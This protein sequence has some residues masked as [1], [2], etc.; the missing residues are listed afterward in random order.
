M[1]T[2]PGL[3]MKIT[4]DTAGLSRGMNRTEKALAGLKS[5]TDRA[6]ASLRTLVS[7]EVG[8]ILAN[9]FNSAANSALN[10]ANSLRGSI[11]ETA[12]LA[13]R[14][15]IAVEALQGLQVAAALSGVNNFS[16]A[17]SKLNVRLGQAAQGN[18][19][20]LD[21][22]NMLGLSFA[23]LEK[24]SPEDRF[25]AV[26]EAIRLLPTELER[27]AAAVKLFEEGGI[28]LLP[29]FAQNLDEITARAERLGIIL[30]SDQTKSIEE[31]NDALY[32]VR[33][34][35]D[36]I[37]GQVTANLAPIITELA[38]Q[39][40]AFV[41][42]YK[43]L[44]EGTG[45]TAL[46][47]SITDAILVGVEF[48]AGVFDAIIS[49][50]DAWGVSFSSAAEFF[51]GAVDIFSRVV[52]FLETVF[53]TAQ[54]FFMFYWSGV[55]K[56]LSELVGLFDQDSKQ[57]LQI[58]SEELFNGSLAAIDR[59]A[60]AAGRIIGAA[61]DATDPGKPGPAQQFVKELQA[62]LEKMRADRGKPKPGEEPPTQPQMGGAAAAAQQA[63][64]AI[65][66]GGQLVDEQAF[67][68][69]DNFRLLGEERQRLLTEQV[70]ASGDLDS[71]NNQALQASDLRSG[72][73]STFLDLA[74][75]RDPALETAK[76]QFE[77]LK[78]IREALENNRVAFEIAGALA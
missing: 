75:G 4:A 34:T 19:D 72:G 6:A 49:G 28:Q 11:D 31:M 26:A 55:T 60:E 54:Y 73:L 57:Y 74:L 62:M 77:E 69:M 58:L 53:A 8:K 32:L 16:E 44:G 59:A 38:N 12:K 27:S 45:G 7:I 64:I 70:K 14:T 76:Q 40:L 24:M 61:A 10:L 51:S 46:A 30:S 39:F 21:T 17:I 35:F 13:Q 29:L 18:K 56:V 15:G 23:D 22:L 1:A 3:A 52:A 68:A 71:R 42:G 9:A 67:R 50:L 36:G 33:A 43:G 2:G 47:D 65:D 41:E 25:K 48:L 20:V 37:I 78:R 66:V 5:S 63:K